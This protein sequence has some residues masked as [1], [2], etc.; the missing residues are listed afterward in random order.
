MAYASKEQGTFEAFNLEKE[1]IVQFLSKII[2]CLKRLC[3]RLP[4]QTVLTLHK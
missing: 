1:N 2:L 3:E 4:T